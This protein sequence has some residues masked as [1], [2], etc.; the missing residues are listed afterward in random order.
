MVACG[1]SALVAVRW[2]GPYRKP[3]K[4][5]GVLNSHLTGNGFGSRARIEYRK[6]EYAFSRHTSRLNVFT[7]RYEVI[8]PRHTSS[9][10]VLSFLPPTQP[11]L[12]SHYVSI[13]IQSFLAGCPAVPS[14]HPLRFL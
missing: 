11:I 1:R 12:P 14:L 6:T 10:V 2:V 3:T 13:T 8:T 7:A 9:G 4:S 5:I